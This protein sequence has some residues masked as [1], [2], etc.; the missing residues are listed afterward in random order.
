MRGGQDQLTDKQPASREPERSSKP[1]SHGVLRRRLR[2]LREIYEGLYIAPYRSA[3]HKEYLRERD[4]FL[5]MGFADLLGVPNPVSFYTLEL[6][7]ELID[8]F[9]E[10]HLRMGMPRAPDGGFR[11]C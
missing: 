7:P 10:W 11:C 9:H 1:T 8:Q 3:I 2:A 5:L 6:Y 4:L